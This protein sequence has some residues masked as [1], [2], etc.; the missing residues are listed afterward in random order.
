MT[1]N[2]KA[3]LDTDHI[4]IVGLGYVGLPLAL[5]FADKGFRVL[6][7][8][9]DTRKIS[10]LRKNK[11]YL[12]DVT[13][14]TLQRIQATGRFHATSQYEKI[15]QA[16]AIIICVPTPLT[17]YDTPNLQY[18][19]AAAREIGN[20]LQRGQLV[21]LESSTFP[22]TTREVLAPTLEQASGLKAGID[23]SVGYSPER[24]DPGNQQFAVEQI[25]KVTSGL[26]PACASLTD[27]LYRR[28]FKQTVPV[29]SPETAEMTKLLENAQRL[30]NISFIN[31]MAYICEEMRLDIWEVVDAAK[32]KPFGFTPYY[33]GPGIGG[34]CIPV[35]PLYLQWKA[36]R[37]GV[38]SK[39]IE[40]SSVYNKTLP[41]R[42]AN[43]LKTLLSGI[44]RPKILV[45]GVAYK[46]NVNDSRESTALELIR[47]LQHNGA[48]VIYHD[49]YISELHHEDLD[50]HSVTLTDDLLR[51]QDCVIIYTD[52]SE[53]PVERIVS[54]A[55]LVFD[56]RNATAK[57]GTKSN[58]IRLG[59]GSI[60]VPKPTK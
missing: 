18:L 13:D 29:S 36:R 50:M 40:L 15:R 17:T 32:T 46:K 35:D 59:T 7:V 24:I 30:I 23:F 39:F 54:L 48:Q 33:P 14:E 19:Q 10:A 34:H 21:I 28:V 44:V 11:S 58:V 57:L 43:K 16:H 3:R 37:F 22:G 25:P 4:A 2:P 27:Q 49:P 1:N 52:H 42:I 45:Y 31:E 38:N 5:L 60:P 6:G 55:P 56:T 51:E 41:G 47:Q 20:Q 8:D 9:V 12:P 53:I 26:T